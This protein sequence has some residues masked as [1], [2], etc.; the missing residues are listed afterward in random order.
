MGFTAYFDLFHLY[1]KVYRPTGTSRSSYT[2]KPVSIPEA[3]SKPVGRSLSGSVQTST[4]DY[5]ARRIDFRRRDEFS[6]HQP[7][8]IAAKAAIHPDACSTFDRPSPANLLARPLAGI[9]R[10][11]LSSIATRMRPGEICANY[12][13]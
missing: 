11:E 8:V 9:A 12:A 5:A 10:S 1:D 13:A 4:M 2:R 7:I 3:T 6:R